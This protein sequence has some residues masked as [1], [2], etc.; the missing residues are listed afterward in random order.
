MGIKNFYKFVE[1][2][3]TVKQCSINDFENKILLVDGNMMIYK[4]IMAIRKNGYDIMKNGKSVTHIHS[5]LNKLL[6]FRKYNITPIFVFDGKPP[7]I[8]NDELKKRDL[9]KTDMKNKYLNAKN[10]IEKKKY[11]YYNFDVSD[12]E[13]KESIQLI[14]I[15]GYKIINSDTE[16]DI[17]LA[18]LSKSLNKDIAGV[19]T[20]DFDILIFGGKTILKNFSVCKK[21]LQIDLKIIKKDTKFNQNM[22]ITL[23]LL[24]GSDYAPSIKG[25]GPVKGYELVSKYKN[26]DQLYNNNIIDEKNY[27]LLKKGY[28]FFKNN[29]LKPKNNHIEQKK[30]KKQIIVKNITTFLKKYN[31]SQDKIDDICNNIVK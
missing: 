15:F 28:N 11:F 9:I 6:N 3:S 1:K 21:F 22:L 19:I 13:I 8:K 4:N 5:M 29:N 10:D 16:A 2:Y 23:S 27:Y 30:I 31:Y 17:T 18:Q 24:L 14:K 12:K 20:D 7:N 26:L 25:I